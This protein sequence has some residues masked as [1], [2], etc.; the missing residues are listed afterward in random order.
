MSVDASFEDGAERPLNLGALDE[1]DLAVISA[2][3]QDAVFPV[4]E[5]TY[6]QKGRRFALLLNRFRWEDKGAARHAPE[7]VQAVLVFDTVLGVATQGVRRADKDMVLSL[8]AIDWEPSEAPSGHIVLT[9]AGDG[10]IRLDCEALE[11][12]LKDVTRPYTAPSR[13]RPSHEG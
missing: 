6:D 5:M 13:K 11:V 3:V 4:T 9:L 7:R 10:A 8:L 2:L 1:D 12:T